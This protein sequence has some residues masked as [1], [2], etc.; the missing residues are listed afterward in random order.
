MKEELK[1]CAHC[2]SDCITDYSDAGY[3]PT[4]VACT[5]SKEIQCDECKVIAPNRRAWNRRA[6]PVVSKMENSEDI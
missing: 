1:P 2:G 6:E 5:P 3:Y 4:D